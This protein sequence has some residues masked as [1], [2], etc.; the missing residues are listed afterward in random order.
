M[1]INLID[2][3]DFDLEG[4]D[5]RGRAYD[6][7]S[8]GVFLLVCLIFTLNPLVPSSVLYDCRIL[9]PSGRTCL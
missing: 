5:F 7:G 4:L 3:A 2:D 8:V 1:S 9:D 6:L